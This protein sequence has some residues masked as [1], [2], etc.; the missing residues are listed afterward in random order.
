MP[1]LWVKA[2][3]VQM[4]CIFYLFLFYPVG[5]FPKAPIL[6]IPSVAA[7]VAPGRAEGDLFN[8]F[9]P[10]TPSYASPPCHPN[11]NSGLHFHPDYG[12]FRDLTWLL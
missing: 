12:R 4:A 11:S 5:C 1:A 6:Q 10:G 7:R 3:V 8:F 2:N 9:A